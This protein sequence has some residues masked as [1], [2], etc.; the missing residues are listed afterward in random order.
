M[1][2]RSGF[3]FKKLLTA[4][5]FVKYAVPLG[6]LA[7]RS[8]TFR[9][10]ALVAGA[11]TAAFFAAPYVATAGKAAFGYAKGAAGVA[12]GALSAKLSSFAGSRNSAKGVSDLTPNPEIISPTE[13]TFFGDQPQQ[14]DNPNSP[15]ARAAYGTAASGAAMSSCSGP[16]S[17]IDFVNNY[18]G[19]DISLV[20]IGATTI[21]TVF[22]IIWYANKLNKDTKKLMKNFIEDLKN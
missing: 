11:G 18:T 6:G 14:F 16:A 20:A 15:S 7:Q 21:A 17:A 3:S 9:K 1:A 5:G 4:K 2:R 19:F 22:W 13:S 8:K 12:K 10:V